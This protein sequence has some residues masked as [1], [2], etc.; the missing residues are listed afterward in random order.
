[1]SRIRALV[2]GS[3]I[4]LM[5]GRSN[6]STCTRL[7]STSS[8]STFMGFPWLQKTTPYKGYYPSVTWLRENIPYMRDSTINWLNQYKCR[9]H[10]SSL[11]SR[12]R[13]QRHEGFDLDK[14]NKKAEQYVGVVAS[15]MTTREGCERIKVK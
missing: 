10:L 4:M 11:N 7:A 2:G 1:M 6:K 8:L 3:R 14:F 13:G 9:K 12:L 15:N 5:H